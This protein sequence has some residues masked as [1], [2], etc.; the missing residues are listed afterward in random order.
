MVKTLLK[1]TAMASLFI[2]MTLTVTKAN[3][4]ETF[5]YG[6]TDNGMIVSTLNEDG[7][8]LTPKWKYEYQYDEQGQLS[9]KKAC[10]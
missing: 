9:E 1:R 8:T 7:K 5:I 4:K 2:L 3:T 6:E 10:L